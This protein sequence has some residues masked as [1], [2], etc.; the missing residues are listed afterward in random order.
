MKRCLRRGRRG[1]LLTLTALS[2]T[3]LVNLP[4][5]AVQVERV[6]SPGGIEA[7]FV[8]DTSI[9]LVAIE[10]SFRGGAALDPKGKAGL[11]NLT[12]ALLD[13]GAGD[14]D[15]QGFQRLLQN[16]S[17]SLDFRASHNN[18]RGSLKTLNRNRDEAV[19][20]LRLALTKARFGAEA[21]ERMRTEIVSDIKR[22]SARPGYIARR[23][24][25]RA[26][27]R[28]HPYGASVSGT[29]TSV[30]AVTV[31]DMRTFMR[32]NIAKDRLIVGVSGDI[33]KSDLAALLDRVF[34]ALP[35]KG[36]PETVPATTP[37][38]L[39]DTFVVHRAVPQSVAVFGLP[40]IARDDPEFYAA[41]VMNHVLGGGSFNSWLFDEV[42]EKRGLAYS[43]YSYLDARPGAPL[44]M[45]SVAT[46]NA[47]MAQS[48]K[49]IRAQIRRMREKGVSEKELR[50]AKLY[51]NGSFPLSFTSTDRIAS[52][53]IT[54]QFYNLG[55]DYLD[56]RATLINAVT[57]RDIARVAKRLLDPDKLIV[58]VV[59][60]PKGVKATAASPEIDS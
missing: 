51:I 55:I 20:L 9:P 31:A 26:V 10:F 15:S 52:I 50:N 24:W 4:A 11:A 29:A 33:G 3:L 23:T 60:E 37:R 8:R 12:S 53:L 18:F 1:L 7:W 36:S 16:L 22:R 21:V 56:R 6:V 2:V 42:R 45:G 41:F 44:W 25:R 13:E 47:S 17:I 58:T 27:F 32:R 35:A 49:I 39:G 30:Q 46:A 59:G 14:L 28:D 40:G 34:G 57:R 43:V 5:H 19:R 38:S 54:L 48:V